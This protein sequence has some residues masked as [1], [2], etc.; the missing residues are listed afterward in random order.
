[1]GLVKTREAGG[2][3]QAAAREG[4][5]EIPS[6]ESHPAPSFP[7]PATTACGGNAGGRFELAG[8]VPAQRSF[9]AQL[10]PSPA[11]HVHGLQT[12]SLV[13]STRYHRI[14]INAVVVNCQAI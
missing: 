4:G 2:N 10:H 5:S 8:A 14:Y 7:P 11:N 3:E 9:R 13:P 6:A 12:M 1:M